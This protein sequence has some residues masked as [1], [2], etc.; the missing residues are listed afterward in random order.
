M[1]NKMKV[2]AW[3]AF[4]L[5]SVLCSA[6]QAFADHDTALLTWEGTTDPRVMGYEVWVGTRPSYQTPVKVGKVT[7][8]TFTKLAPETYY[9]TVTSYDSTGKRS[10]MSNRV[11]KTISTCVGCK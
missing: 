10:V 2:L 9:F 8:Y 11:I 7:S 3:S 5:G 6:G 1:R 4:L